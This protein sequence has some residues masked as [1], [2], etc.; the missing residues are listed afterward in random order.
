MINQARKMRIE[1]V[2]RDSVVTGYQIYPIDVDQPLINQFMLDNTCVEEIVYTDG[3]TFDQKVEP[4]E[5]GNC[6]KKK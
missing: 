3:A 5:G 4:C 1:K 6:P 2:T